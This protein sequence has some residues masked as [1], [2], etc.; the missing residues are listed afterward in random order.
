MVG[1]KFCIINIQK[2]NENLSPAAIRQIVKEIKELTQ[3]P[4]EGIKI[5]PNEE[6]FT[7]I[8]SLIEGPGTR[9]RKSIFIYHFM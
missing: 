3:N 2:A 7:D 4:P 1:P 9:D 5:I 8:Q 6:D